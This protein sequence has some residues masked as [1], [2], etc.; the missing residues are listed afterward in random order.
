[1]NDSHVLVDSTEAKGGMRKDT[2]EKWGA[3]LWLPSPT[4]V[5]PPLVLITRALF[6]RSMTWPI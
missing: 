1:M 5:V 2:F 3:G 4:P 6:V